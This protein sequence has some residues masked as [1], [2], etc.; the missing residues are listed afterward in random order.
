MKKL[1]LGCG[2]HIFPSWDNLDLEPGPGGIVCDLSKGLPYPDASVDYIFSEHVIEHLTRDLALGML[3][4]CRRVLKSDATIRIATPDMKVAARDYLDGRIT[5]WEHGGFRP[6]T[7][8]QMINDSMRL[9]GHQFVYDW[10]ELELLFN[11][12][13]FSNIM[14]MPYRVSD[15][16]ELNGLETRGFF[17]DL[18]LEATNSPRSELPLISVVMSSYNHGRFVGRSILSVLNQTLQ[19]IELVITDDGSSDDTCDVIRSF[20]DP[21]INFVAMGENRG[22]CYSMNRAIRRSRAPYIAV[23]N[24]DDTFAPDKLEKQLQVLQGNPGVGAVF[25][26]VNFINEDDQIVD[27]NLGDFNQPNYRRQDWLAKL[28]LSGNCLAHPSALIRRAC[29]LQ[30]GFYDERFRQLPDYLMWLRLLKTWDFMVLPERLIN[31]RRLNNAGN[32]SAASPDVLRR[33]FWE[34]KQLIKEIMSLSQADFLHVAKFISKKSPE[35]MVA[36]PRAIVLADI[37]LQVGKPILIQAAMEL[38]YEHT[39]DRGSGGTYHG[40]KV[41]SVYATLVTHKGF[42]LDIANE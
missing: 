14:R 13:G 3:Q 33:A 11:Q 37:A 31:F 15:V 27:A 16:V 40:L 10:T 12:A 25:T 17:E 30:E 38:L 6:Q 34:S 24:S 4:E 9:W 19:N 7:P 2:P 28:F 5:R 8:C 36:N 1:H 29:Y 39:P 23:I 42:E 35:W 41:P 20:T 21:R 32:E 26:H 18:I 22:A